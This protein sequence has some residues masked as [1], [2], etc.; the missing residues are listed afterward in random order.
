MIDEDSKK[1]ELISDGKENIT[2]YSQFSKFTQGL[3]VFIALFILAYYVVSIYSI[4]PVKP[5]YLQVAEAKS[6]KSIQVDISDL[7][8]KRFK[9]V[10]WHGLPIGIYKRTDLDFNEINKRHPNNKKP[11][12]NK[13]IIQQ[14]KPYLMDNIEILD[15]D[16]RSIK[17]DFFVFILLS[18][19]QVCPLNIVFFQDAIDKN[20]DQYAQIYE[21]CSQHKYDMNGK[22]SLENFYGNDPYRNKLHTNL[23]LIPN[24]IFVNDNIIEF[25]PND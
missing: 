21:K 20:K 25:F 13:D 23:L 12:V 19:Y 24:H 2:L 14:L 16:L 22:L 9:E 7:K 17:D 8:N 15:E 5:Q 6:V 18:P 4:D 3:F 1:D 11:E 10:S